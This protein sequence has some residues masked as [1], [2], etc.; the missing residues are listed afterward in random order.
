MN[1]VSFDKKTIKIHAFTVFVL[2]AIAVLLRT[3]CLAF[4]YEELNDKVGYYVDSILPTVFYAVCCLSVVYFAVLAFMANKTPLCFNTNEDNVP[5]KVVSACVMV[6]F[7]AFF[8]GTVNSTEFVNLSVVFDLLVKLSSLMA[9]IYF[10][11]NIFS[12]E[13]RKAL[14]VIFGFGIVVWSICILAITYFDVYVPMNSP[15][16][17]QIHFALIALMVFFVS[18]FRSSLIKTNKPIYIFSLFIVVFF[19]GVETVPSLIK[20]FALGMLDYD[21]LYYDVVIFTLFLYSSVRLISLA[22]LGGIRE[23][24]EE[25]PP[26]EI[27]DETENEE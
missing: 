10:I 25:I 7:V 23:N 8:V 15:D 5:I 16:K 17:T 11:M 20:Y 19:S 24:T 2:T 14:Q 13:S 26:V 9:I 27:L 6:G 21:Y 1:L 22:F 4:F 12:A 3:V 18:E